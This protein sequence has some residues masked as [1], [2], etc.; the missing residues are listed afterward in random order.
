MNGNTLNLNA[1]ELASQIHPDSEKDPVH[2]K[3]TADNHVQNYTV[4]P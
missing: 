2:G 3:K 1:T 4:W